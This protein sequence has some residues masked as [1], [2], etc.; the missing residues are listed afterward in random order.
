MPRVPRGFHRWAGSQ[1]RG[2]YQGFR[3]GRIHSPAAE[4]F[5]MIQRTGMDGVQATGLV[6]ANRSGSVS[7]GPTG[8]GTR[9]YLT[10]ANVAT[11]TGA[12]DLSSTVAL[13]L[14]AATVSNLL[15][16]GSYSGGL[17][18]I[19]LNVRPLTPGDFITAVWSNANPGDIITLVV[20][21]DQDVLTSW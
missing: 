9:W 11:T 15:G 8:W 13:Y 6:A 7:L 17:D 18:T 19:G 3:P 16:G 5:T 20:Y 12:A 10:Q 2:A 21:G 1:Q 14:G 4:A